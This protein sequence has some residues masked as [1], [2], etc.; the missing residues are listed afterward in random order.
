VQLG[1]VHGLLQ[2]RFVD[3]RLHVGLRGRPDALADLGKRRPVETRSGDW[4]FV[5]LGDQRHQV[6]PPVLD[7]LGDDCPNVAETRHAPRRVG[8]G[9]GKRGEPELSRRVALLWHPRRVNDPDELG[10]L[11]PHTH[12][13]QDVD[14][15]ETRAAQV[16]PPDCGRPRDQAPWPGIEQGRHRTLVRGH[17]SRRR[18]VYPRQDP[19]PSSSRL[20]K[21][22]HPPPAQPAVKCLAPADNAELFQEQIRQPGTVIYRFDRH[23]STVSPPTDKMPSRWLLPADPG[24]VDCAI[25]PL[26]WCR[27]RNRQVGE[28][29]RRGPAGGGEAWRGGGGEAPR[30]ALGGRMGLAALAG[31]PGDCRNDRDPGRLLPVA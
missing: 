30:G 8:Y 1:V 9:A 18:R 20:R 17:D 4:P 14:L 12:P 31:S 25:D 16:I 26:Y 15:V 11:P 27:L 28:V 6:T 3:Q 19:L 23:G 24:P 5:Q 7:R 13:D 2:V 10:A 21:V 22:V 29:G